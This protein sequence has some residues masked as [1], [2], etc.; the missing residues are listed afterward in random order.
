[1]N[2]TFGLALHH[3]AR[4][5]L[6]CT[7]LATGCMFQGD[8]AVRSPGEPSP[9][10]SGPPATKQ[11]HIERVLGRL[12]FTLD[13]RPA[14]ESERAPSP[15]T[16]LH[17][18]AGG[19]QK[20]NQGRLLEAL[21]LYVEAVLAAPAEAEPLEALGRCLRFL[22]R[23][24]AAATAFATALAHQP[25][26]TSSLAELA[27]TQEALGLREDAIAS[28]LRV[29][30]DES[31]QGMAHARLAAA[32]HLSGDRAAA[33]YHY[34]QALELRAAVPA[35]V[36]DTHSED[37]SAPNQHFRSPA[38][39]I[40][41]GEPIRIDS[42]GTFGAA[43]TSVVASPSGE[44]VA[45]W[46]DLRERGA[47]D[48]W[49]LGAGLSLDGGQTWSDQLLRPAGVG[50]EKFEGDPMS[51]Y[52]PRTGTFWVG[53]IVF[54]DGS[55][56]VARK[57]PGASS[58]EA[59]VVIQQGVAL[60]KGW[61]AAGPAPGNPSQT[62]LYVAYNLGLQTSTDLGSTWSEV[63]PLTF[64][65]AYHPR[66]GPLGELYISFWDFD[67]GIFL[68]RSFDG[69]ATLSAPI[70]IAT[71]VDTWG[72]QD[73]SR[74]PG[75]FRVPPLAYLAIDPNNGTLFCVYF[76]TTALVA[77]QANIDLYL[78]RSSDQGATW[79][80]PQA[81]NSDGSPPG[82][83]FHPWLE[84]DARGRLHLLF[85]DSRHTV[86]N[87]DAIDGRFDVYYALS[88]DDGQSWQEQRLT[89]APFSSAETAWPGF[90]DEQFLGDFQ[91]LAVAGNRVTAVYASTQ[92]GDLDIFAQAL[93]VG[94][95][96]TG[97][98]ESGDFSAWSH[99]SP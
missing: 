96:F 99:V 37:L 40:L 94:E 23:S 48:Y 59:P 52:D 53:G 78:T 58:L 21:E 4:Y 55:I 98:F 93:S 56:F 62:R 32:Y 88:T 8:S 63:T 43:E 74:F 80:T 75:R 79:T 46:N 91:G 22:G 73:G 26:R 68:Q 61:L 87:D 86:Q 13:V 7:V 34:A 85:Y 65:L 29:L 81:I 28:W 6:I 67:D 47:G 12:R 50:A 1:M 15:E 49:S 24:G 97:G 45:A 27:K 11:Q 66:V 9:A 18:V 35:A 2:T 95:I 76:D 92:N 84:V 17:L 64:G 36:M 14:V 83:Q 57:A 44:I 54:F 33:L 39:P 20:L 19:H 82:D 38:L 10:V 31:H 42:G 69:G 90:P 3:P 72:T 60:D 89:A 51:A 77:D 41:V 71:R 5:I 16:A 70:R 25:T 30:A